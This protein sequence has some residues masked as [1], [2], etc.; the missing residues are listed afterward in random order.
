V[1]VSVWQ[2]SNGI[3]ADLVNYNITPDGARMV[4]ADGV[5]FG[6]RVPAEWRSVSVTTISP[7]GNPSA[8]ASLQNGWAVV[9]LRKLTHFASVKLMQGRK[10]K[11]AF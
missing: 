10:T 11:N 8:T 5:T 9:H 7:D 3:F 6:I 1:G 2:A 4:S